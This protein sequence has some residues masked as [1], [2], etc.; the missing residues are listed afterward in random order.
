MKLALVALLLVACRSGD[1]KKQPTEAP[2]TIRVAVIGGMLETGFWQAIVERYEAQSPNTVELAASGPKPVVIGAFRDGNIDLITL[3][4]SDAIVN[5]TVENRATDLAAWA[6]N[7][8]VIVGPASDPAGI[9]GGRDAIAALKKLV[10]AKAKILVHASLGAD[11]VLHDLEHEAGVTLPDA[12]V[13]SGENQHDILAKAAELGAYTLV[14]RI[15][16]LLG[17]LKQD[18]IEVMVKGDP[19]LRRPYLVAVAV[20]PEEPARIAAAKDLAAFLRKPE[21]QQW[22][23]TYAKGKYDDQ[24]LFFPVKTP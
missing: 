8:L 4:S 11:G 17:K 12:V 23:A 6:Q 3:H 1:T 10:A 18:G 20:R 22:I 13:F 2:Q 19:R 7:D 15:P 9:R 21:T 16:V 24:P 5:L 14:G